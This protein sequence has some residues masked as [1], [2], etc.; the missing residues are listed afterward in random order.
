MMSGSCAQ[1][2]LNYMS[3]G[4]LSKEN[5]VFLLGKYSIRLFH[6]SVKASLITHL[7]V[8]NHNHA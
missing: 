6:F 3:P 4:F 8:I 7:Y 1:P 5:N 2:S